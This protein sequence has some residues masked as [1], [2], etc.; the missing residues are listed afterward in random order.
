MN[1]VVSDKNKSEKFPEA[2]L[3]KHIKD[4]PNEFTDIQRKSRKITQDMVDNPPKIIKLA[5]DESKENEI[6]S[7]PN[8]FP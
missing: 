3:R 7:I 1:F 6:E 4:R 2:E 5:E 8:L